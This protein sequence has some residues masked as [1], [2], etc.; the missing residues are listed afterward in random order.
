MTT[1]YLARHGQSDWNATL[2]WQ[3]HA[4]RPLTEL[5]R[6]QA[7]ELAEHLADTA[8]DAVYSSD[9]VRARETAAPIARLKGLEIVELPELREVDVGSWSGLSRT[10]AQQRFPEGYARWTRGGHGWDDGE[11]YEQMTERVVGAALRIAEAHPEESV[12]LVAH[13]GPIRA[14]HAV[15]L[16]MD[17]LSHRQLR[18]VEPNAHLSRVAVEDGRIARLD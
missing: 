3:G 17:V 9:L 6:R 5:G 4:D 8:I 10:E 2:R 15:S 16:G 1:L 14:L 18:R 11:T 12:L 7:A 13:G